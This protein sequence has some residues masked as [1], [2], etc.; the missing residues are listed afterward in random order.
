VSDVLNGDYCVKVGKVV[1]KN[2]DLTAQSAV[3]SLL[4]PSS[5]MFDNANSIYEYMRFCKFSEEQ[6]AQ[7]LGI[8]ERIVVHKLLLLKFTKIQRQVILQS[9]I[10][11]KCA[12]EVGWLFKADKTKVIKELAQSQFYGKK[13]QELVY[14]KIGQ[15]KDRQFCDCS[16]IASPKKILIRDVGLFFNTVERAVKLMQSGGYDVQ[17]VRHENEKEYR[18]DIKVK[19]NNKNN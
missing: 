1:N 9:G 10:C 14:D 8:D 4:D 17:N 16:K 2:Q 18:L 11:E 6:V 3:Q 13:A 19:K 7:K 15:L 12:I 5:N